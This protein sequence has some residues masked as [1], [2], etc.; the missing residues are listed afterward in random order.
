MLSAQYAP[1]KYGTA[2]NKQRQLSYPLHQRVSTRSSSIFN[3]LITET[4]TA[5]RRG[6][7]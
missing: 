5:T 2:D 6:D 3:L 7:T 4:K 1:N